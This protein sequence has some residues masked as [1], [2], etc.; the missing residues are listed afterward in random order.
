[1]LVPLIV[2]NI[3][4]VRDLGLAESP[5]FRPLGALFDPL[6]NDFD[7]FR[8]KRI[9]FGRHPL[10]LIFRSEAFENFTITWVVGNDCMKA[11]IKL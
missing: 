8:K 11:R 6:A 7:F 2:V 9:C 3:G 4:D 5:M 1:M 10:V